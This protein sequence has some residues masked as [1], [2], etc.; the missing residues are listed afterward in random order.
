MDE[1]Q[2]ETERNQIDDKDEIG[3]EPPDLD[4]V[5]HYTGHV[6]IIV[7]GNWDLD[8]ITVES[9]ADQTED[10]PFLEE[11]TAMNFAMIDANVNGDAVMDIIDDYTNDPDI[12][13]D[14]TE[15]QGFATGSPEFQEKLEEHHSQGP[16]LAG[17]DVDAAWDFTNA[18]GE[19]SPGGTAPTPDQDIVDDIG[20]A[21]GIS[22][23]DNEPLET[24]NLLEE[25][26]ENRW[27]LDPNSVDDSNSVTDTGDL[28]KGDE[29][30]DDF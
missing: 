13:E 27:E 15:R 2:S 16:R 14:F 7:P 12:L 19:E 29:E 28:A 22:Y 6:D 4:P 24:A 5:D 3:P 25:R 10:L 21:V 30:L 23:K 8:P 9:F 1:N 20:G 18:S 26:D 17:G 11:D